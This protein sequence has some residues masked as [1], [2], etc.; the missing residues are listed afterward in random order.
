LKEILNKCFGATRYVQNQALEYIENNPDTSLTHISLRNNTMKSDKELRKTENTHEQWLIDVPYDTRQLALKQLADNFKSN[1]TMLENKQINHFKMH[2]RSKRTPYQYCFVDKAALDISNM[3]IFKRRFKGV[4]K[5]RKK[6]GKWIRKNISN[7]ESDFIIT[8]EKNR[9]YLCLTMT[10]EPDMIIQPYNRVALDPGV[11]TF[12]TFY[13]DQGIA[14]K[15]GDNICDH[16]IDIGKKEDRLKSLLKKNSYAKRTR[17]NLKKRCF[18]LRTKIKNIV[19]DLHWKT[20]NYL[21]TTFRHI[22]LPSFEVSN[23]TRKG[24]PEKARTINS[25]AVRKMLSLSHYAF[26]KKLLYMGTVMGC[27]IDIV[28]E[29]YTTCVCGCCGQINK[30]IGGGKVFICSKCS[31]VLDRDYNGARNV[32]LKYYSH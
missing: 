11:R 27:K 12:Q 22:L 26:K 25:K 18:L 29:A 15:I 6:M 2:Y 19:N 32:D 30:D 28:N 20:A 1:F 21:C 10:G 24:L 14:G 17:Y 9:Y 16:L 5:T 4:I 31:L 8:R 23:M 13:S 3:R 7:V